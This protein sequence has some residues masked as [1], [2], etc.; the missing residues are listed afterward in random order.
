M[1][2]LSQNKLEFK[3]NDRQQ[4][5]MAK[6]KMIGYFEQHVAQASRDESHR[7]LTLAYNKTKHLKS[8]Q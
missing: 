3:Y 2:R 7:Y 6:E 8:M 1:D 5:V 4:L